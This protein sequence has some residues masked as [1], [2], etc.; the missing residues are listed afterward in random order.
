MI[1]KQNILNFLLS[2]SMAL[3]AFSGCQPG[4]VLQTVEVPDFSLANYSTYDFYDIEVDGDSTGFS[5]RIK[6]MEEE[7]NLQLAGKGLKHVEEEPDLQINLGIALVELMQTTET[8]IVVDAPRYAGSPN[9]RWESQLLELGTYE[10][11]TFVIHFVESKSNILVWEGIAQSA[12]VKKDKE[13][14]K[15]IAASIKKLFKDL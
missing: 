15:N 7:I 12:I 8:S 4:N 9:Y 1:R 13:A 2:G 5:E 10:H 6:W 3:L 11:G 14:K